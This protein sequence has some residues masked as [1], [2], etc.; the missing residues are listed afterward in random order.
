MFEE[1]VNPS[2][3]IN[4]IVLISN[5]NFFQKFIGALKDFGDLV[6]DGSVF[7]R[8]AVSFDVSEWLIENEENFNE[9]LGY[10]CFYKDLLDGW[11]WRIAWWANVVVV[12]SVDL[13]RQQF[14]DVDYVGEFILFQFFEEMHCV[15]V[16][17]YGFLLFRGEYS[18]LYL[19]MAV[20]ILSKNHI[21]KPS[22]W[23]M[24]WHNVLNVHHVLFFN[25]HYAKTIFFQLSHINQ[26]V[27]LCF[28]FRIL[29]DQ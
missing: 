15:N 26:S 16:G 6:S 19:W 25:F 2:W 8:F 14:N 1:K 9:K 11:V 17:L 20:L 7:W 21:D 24:W 22:N 4:S 28:F 27:F 18:S 29:N 12:C 10:A 5:S 13:S 3:E 23:L